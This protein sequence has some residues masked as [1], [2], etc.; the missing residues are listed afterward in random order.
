MYLP[1]TEATNSYYY[2]AVYEANMF[3]LIIDQR[4]AVCAGL[5]ARLGFTTLWPGIVTVIT[6]F[7][8]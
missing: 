4:Q 6:S 8:S 3:M 1:K 5:Y 7:P 2:T